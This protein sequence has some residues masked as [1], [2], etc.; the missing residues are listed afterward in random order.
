MTD[1]GLKYDKYEV[2]SGSAYLFRSGAIADSATAISASVSQIIAITCSANFNNRLTKL[3]SIN[4]NAIITISS[5]SLESTNLANDTKLILRY[6]SSLNQIDNI[7]SSSDSTINHLLGGIKTNIIYV[8][9][10]LLNNDDSFAVAYKTVRALTASIGYNKIFKASLVDDGSNFKLSSSLGENM[11]IGSS[12]R[13]RDTLNYEL[14]NDYLLSSSGFFILTSLISGSVA[15]PD[16]TG[17]EVQIDGM[18]IGTSFKV[19]GGI[20]TQAFAYNTI[21]AG[22]GK[23]NQP[24]FEGFVFTT[25]ASLGLKLD[26]DDKKSGIIT[27]SN[28]AKL[29]FSGSGKIGVNTTDPQVGFDMIADEVQFQKPGSRKGLKINDEGNIESFNRDVTSATTGSEFIL[30]YSRGTTITQASLDALGIVDG[31]EDDATA[32]AYVNALKPEEQNTILEKLEFLGFINSPEVGDTLGSIRFIAESGSLAGFDSRIAGEA[33]LIKA[34]VNSINNT[35]VQADL[36]FSVAGKEG[37]SEQKLLLDANNNHELT[38]SLNVT[39]NLTIGAGIFHR[40]DNDTYI[41]FTNDAINFKVGNETLMQI[42]ESTQDQVLIGDGGDVDFR[43]VTNL[44]STFGTNPS[45]FVEGSS[46]NVGIGINTPTSKLHVVGDAFI[47]GKLTA[48]EFHT[49]FI[50]SSIIYQSGSTQF[51][52]SADDTHTFTGHITSSGNIS[53]SGIITA[54]SSNIITINGGSF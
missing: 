31:I 2:I 35:G 29:Y 21:Q 6:V 27:G 20:E 3:T 39:N 53:A 24:F 19:G 32:V 46:G 52:N 45:L 36:I 23:I 43:V 42:I 49:E 26:P 10:P 37:A 41:A 40:G 5:G 13:V 50:S 51:G 30:K 44:Q 8:D 48:Q 47:T 25:S 16:F 12:F 54:L 28:S 15:T 1:Y 11:S 7:V 17:T 22:S 38:G 34:V 14:P 4:A 18:Q 33:A 9:V